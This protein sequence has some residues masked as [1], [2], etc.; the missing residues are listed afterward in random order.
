MDRMSS[1]TQN[2]TPFSYE[3]LPNEI[4]QMILSQIPEVNNAAGR[5]TLRSVSCVNQKFHTTAWPFLM[6]CYLST[7]ESAL[8]ALSSA[9]KLA[10]LAQLKKWLTQHG[11]QMPT[12]AYMDAFKRTQKLTD[13]LNL[14]ELVSLLRE[15]APAL[16]TSSAASLSINGMIATQMSA[17]SYHSA[18]GR[19]AAQ[20][21]DF[22]NWLQ[23][24]FQ[25]Q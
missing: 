9:R 12:K 5:P 23:S 16:P 2:S 17:S 3:S 14:A 22:S 13:G 18:S 15:T 1:S 8:P 21:Q 24:N 20:V 7:V 10:T 11:D 6:E 25:R 19:L 4:H